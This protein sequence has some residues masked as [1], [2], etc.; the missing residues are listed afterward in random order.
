M[1]DIFSKEKRSAVMAAIKGKDTSPELIVCRFLRKNR[2]YFQRHYSR[3]KGC[4]D[5]AQPRKKKAVFIDGDFWH[6]YKF[7]EKRQR[8]EKSQQVYWIKKIERNMVRDR[9]YSGEL[10]RDGWE[11]MHVWEHLIIKQSSRGET[12]NNILAFLTS[13]KPSGSQGK[14]SSQNR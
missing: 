13:E 8:L 6:G 9:E 5:I 2:V 10:A 7:E 3:A 12:L 11:V 1:A 4:P 14:P